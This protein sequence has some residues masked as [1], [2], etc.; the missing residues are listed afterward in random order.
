MTYSILTEA[1]VKSSV[2]DQ[3]PAERAYTTFWIEDADL[4]G[5]TTSLN[6][7]VVGAWGGFLFATKRTATN[8]FIG[9]TS[10]FAA[11]DAE[12]NDKIFFRLKYDIHPD[13]TS[14][15]TQGKIQWITSADAVFNSTKEVTF[16]T[17]PD[18]KWHFYEVDMGEVSSWVGNIVNVRFFPAENGAF[19]D[20][21]FLNF[22]E[23]GTTDFTF[24]FDN[25]IA[26]FPGKL[27]GGLPLAAAITITK[28]VNDKLLVNIDDYGFVQITLTPQTAQPEIIARD[29]ALQ[30]GTVDIGGYL[31]ADAFIDS[32]TNKLI[33]ESGTLD[34]DSSVRV[35]SGT[36]TAGVSL[37]L[38]NAGGVFIG[39]TEDGEAPSSGFTPL[40]AYRP[41]TLEIISMFDNDD[42]LPA[43]TLEP[44]QFIVE[45]GKRDFGLSNR[46]LR[47]EVAVEGRGES[48]R[49]QNIIT[50][51]QFD[52]QGRTLIDLNHP[53]TD[54]GELEK[55]FVNGVLDTTGGS[56]WKIF[57]PKLDG[58]L[59]FI[60]EG[61]IGTTTITQN[62][63]GGLVLTTEPGVFVANVSSSNIKV[64]RGDLLGIFNASLHVNT[65]G[66]TKEDALYYSISGD[67]T[68]NITP[69]PPSGA[70][71]SG[72]PIYARGSGTKHRAVVD[73]DLNRR[74]NIDKIRVKGDEDLI[75]LEYNIAVATSAVFSVDTPGD[76]TVCW[77]FNENTGARVCDERS[78]TAFN[79][80]AL[81]D[82]V[83]LSENGISS[84]GSRIT[85]SDLT[86]L[87]STL[88]G[89][90]VLGATY[91]Y[92]NGDEEF[93]GTFEFADR[94]PQSF[95]FFRDPIAIDCIFSQ[96][97]PPVNKPISKAVIY[98]KDKKNQ[99]SWQIER[100][101][102]DEGSAGSKQGF[103]LIPESTINS[104]RIDTK[105][106]VKLNN[107]ITQKPCSFRASCRRSS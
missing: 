102:T 17:I 36:N 101:T 70:G 16:T 10:D 91:F 52:A 61:S 95:G 42:S 77:V 26:G 93:L 44:Q 23:I 46:R 40:S 67:I 12:V 4:Q 50:E 3:T 6:L 85:N 76:H 7:D 32:S 5:W 68:T 74:L 103:K 78:N 87:G 51:G 20:E 94:D 8:G 41:T 105:E 65:L 81:N 86:S 55:I 19:N 45:G 11:V 100:K 63:G 89:A 21:F 106:I 59:E 30:L 43:F 88:G 9:P 83:I 107:F 1:R 82:N 99:R 14:P 33:I 72:L 29:I 37:G 47:T 79:V 31:R 57:R 22:F 49:G 73:I 15:A 66:T 27:T 98:F 56:K 24:S 92:I 54:G 2:A 80:A 18:G 28:D 71:E 69:P 75:D 96:T 48:H 39:T 35:Q 60:D 104:V 62:P 25:S 38:V 58:T 64:R 97:E 34:S 84:F 90:N 13:N 53:F